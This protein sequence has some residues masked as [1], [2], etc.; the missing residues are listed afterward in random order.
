[1]ELSFGSSGDSS[2]KHFGFTGVVKLVAVGVKKRHD[3]TGETQISDDSAAMVEA[4]DASLVSNELQFEL[5]INEED[6]ASFD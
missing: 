6:W 2:L 5:D 4:E 3:L 1:M